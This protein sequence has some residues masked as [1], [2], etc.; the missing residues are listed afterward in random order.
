MTELTLLGARARFPGGLTEVAPRTFAWVQPNGDLSES[1]AGL[2][3]GDGASLL[4]DTLFDTPLTERMLA[5]MASETAAA[6]IATC[7]NTHGDGDH[8]FGNSVLAADVRTVASA[9]ARR[10]MEHEDPGALARSKALAG[11]LAT[12]VRLP[13]VGRVLPAGLRSLGPYLAAKLAPYDLGGVR[14]R[15]AAETFEDRLTLDAGGRAV[16]VLFVGPAHT[17]GDAIVW[18]PDVRVVFAADIAFVG[19]TPIMWAGPLASWLAALDAVRALEPAVVVPGHGPVCTVSELD[20]VA[21]YLRWVEAE[22]AGPVAAG[23]APLAVAREMVRGDGFAPFAG[24]IA[25]ERL[26]A[27]LHAI[28]RAARGETTPPGPREIAAIF[29][30]VA[31]LATELDGRG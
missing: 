20:A 18:V 6:P 25:P 11:G 27:T 1:N 22:G 26:A 3:V 7:V 31:V 13:L 23:R 28:R 30:D 14:T 19:V 10:Q 4:V 16:E 29:G 17:A 5:A 24:L 8:W 2:V 15:P 21:D 9:P 12:V